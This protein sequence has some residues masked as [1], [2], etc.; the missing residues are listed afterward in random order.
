MP[1]N[2]NKFFE[3]ISMDKGEADGRFTAI[4]MRS[5]PVHI[6]IEEWV[7]GDPDPV[8][9]ELGESV[10]IFEEDQFRR[11]LAWGREVAG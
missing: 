8:D 5:G 10:F 3:Q 7:A 6:A 11:F 2:S 1:D 9:S 4:K